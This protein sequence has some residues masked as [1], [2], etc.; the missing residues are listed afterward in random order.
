MK[1]Y[2]IKVYAKYKGEDKYQLS[3]VDSFFEPNEEEDI[4]LYLEDNYIY[5]HKNWNTKYDIKEYFSD[6][7]S[8]II[9]DPSVD[10][11]YIINVFVDYKYKKEEYFGN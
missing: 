3:S 1:F 6:G 7:I 8:R 10:R 9:I 4:K 2:K 5:N 11:Y